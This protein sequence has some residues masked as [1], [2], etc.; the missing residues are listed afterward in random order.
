MATKPLAWQE[1]GPLNSLKEGVN[2]F[3]AQGEAGATISH[4][5]PL[6]NKEAPR[7]KSEEAIKIL[8]PGARDKK[9]QQENQMLS[10]TDTAD[11][12]E[13][14]NQELTRI[15]VCTPRETQEMVTEL[16]QAA[17]FSEAL[18]AKEE[19]E[20]SSDPR[21]DA[22]PPPPALSALSTEDYFEKESFPGLEGEG[23]AWISDAEII[24]NP[25]E[26]PKS[27][28]RQISLDGPPLLTEPVNR[29]TNSSP[30]EMT[31]DNMTTEAHGSQL[32]VLQESLDNSK[33]ENMSRVAAAAINSTAHHS[34]SDRNSSYDECYAPFA[35]KS[36]EKEEL[37]IDIMS[38]QQQS[39]PPDFRCKP[40]QASYS[41]NVSNDQDPTSTLPTVPSVEHQ[42]EL[43]S[44]S[45]SEPAPRGENQE[46]AQQVL[47]Q[48][49]SP[50]SAV[51]MELCNRGGAA[52]QGSGC[53]V[54][55]REM[56]RGA[57]ERIE[58]ES[59]QTGGE[60]GQRES[61]LEMK[62]V[63]EQQHGGGLLTFS[64]TVQAQEVKVGKHSFVSSRKT[65]ME[66]DSCDDSQSDSGVSADF[67]P[68]STLEGNTTIS[69]GT[70]AASP[71]ETPIE[72]E[73]RRAVERE[74]SLRR[75][76]GL[77]N[78]PTAPEYV[79][80]PLRK[81]VLCQSI[82]PNSERCQ[83]KDRQFAGK[84]MQQEIHEETQR[85]QDLVKLGKVPG[86]Y[87]KGTV[88]QVKDRK[89]LFE[90]FQK[91]D[92]ST[93][94][95]SARSQ[96]WSSASDVSTLEDQ[97]D[98]SL[99]A[100]TIGGSHVERVHTQS[101]NLAKAR[102]TPR[103]PGFSEGKGCQLIILENSLSVPALKLYHAR[104]QAQPVTVVDS[105][106]PSISSSRTGGHDGIKVREHEKEEVEDEGAPKENPFFKLRL[107]TNLVKVEQD[108]REAQEREKDLHKQR[109]SLYG[110]TESTKGAGV[111]VGGPVIIAEGKTHM[112]SSSSPNGLAVPDLPGSLS[113]GETRPTTARQSVGKLGMWPPAQ[114][115]EEKINQPEV[116]QG[117]LTPRQKTPLVQR[118]ES[119]LVNGHNTE[120]D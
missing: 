68:C 9:T 108:I 114:S 25:S 97:E 80:I 99:Q 104:P 6:Q 45:Q 83:G 101:Q 43:L 2:E 19:S 76:R 56:H 24:S 69:T 111:G 51:A 22:F 100:S 37:S 94:N 26:N 107:S 96:S 60:G 71:K 98:I 33:P 31:G 14:Q 53:A 57:G 116:L 117:P 81:T 86:F 39:T 38:C 42:E 35:D 27:P 120:D 112:L 10:T 78:P 18:Q 58:G 55:V 5:S 59:K 20:K 113:R 62:R 41:A 44:Q 90:A 52:S 23:A 15:S 65:R 66:S 29:E 67:S 7:A 64:K 4:D 89:Q 36:K 87:D 16:E 115:E 21:E 30:E 103:G 17:Q 95:L 79:E 63:L 70:P 54:A 93:L 92:E 28:D 77:P 105:G 119:G 75:S 12:T 1:Q 109:I 88:R 74:H 50:L 8:E 73:I 85:E 46:A 106:R 34:P 118:W 61:G 3:W 49:S 110:G 102:G 48:S 82:T 40:F 32:N 72:R 11:A 91:P 13:S 47:S 84:K